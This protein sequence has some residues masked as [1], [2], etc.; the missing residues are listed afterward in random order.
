M[1]RPI[2]L[3]LSLL[4]GIVILAGA[5]PGNPSKVPAGPK[6]TAAAPAKASAP[7]A[8][9]A[10]K[11]YDKPA[12]TS[13]ASNPI[14]LSES[15]LSPAEV[16]AKADKILQDEI[17][18]GS[19]TSPAG[20]CDDETFL[21]RVTLDLVGGI[22]TPEELTKFILDNSPTK[23]AAVV[24][25]LLA[26]EGYGRNWAHYWRD[27]ILARRSE[28]RALIVAQPL[29]KYMEEE[30][31][32][33]TPWDVL[34]RSFITAKGP[35]AEN[36]DTA[37]FMAQ[38]G[39][40]EDVASEITRIFM[41]IQISCA[42]CHNHPTDRW[43]REQF[44]ELAAFFPR[45]A[46]RPTNVDNVRSFEVVG[47]DRTPM[48]GG[49]G[50]MN[51][52]PTGE[53]F[54]TD[55]KNPASKGTR[56]E[57]VFFATGDKLSPGKTDEERRKDLAEWMTSNR[58]E[59]FAKAIIN[60]LWSEL[61]GEGFYEPVDDMGPDRGCTAPK[62]MQLLAQ[63]FVGHNYDVKWLF[64]TIMD[65]AAYQRESRSRRNP[66]ETPFAS[67]THQQLRADQIYLSLTKALGM[68]EPQEAAAGGRPGGFG[69]MGRNPR[70]QFGT[71]FN[72]DPSTRRDEVSGSIPQALLMMNSSE[73]ARYETGKNSFTALGKLL[74]DTKNDDAVVV[75]LYLRCLARVPKDS[76]IKTCLEH[77]KKVSSRTEAF[78]D[79]LWSLVNS[80]EFLHRK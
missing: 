47:V 28:D 12:P 61:V 69:G 37:I 49:G 56:M 30:L 9:A 26:K 44:H 40:T 11:T 23:R 29:T 57:P 71:T 13:K 6:A 76:E 70:G 63:E 1:V 68:G 18:A 73:L 52:R 54:M 62:T 17:L 78:E 36:G 25:Q 48:F 41:G 21:R 65:T 60:R 24:E 33:N 45:V 34:A 32:K 20:K 43:Q 19:K 51:R 3:S 53:H 22:P 2:A 66:A 55:L 10:K 15:K 79:V 16:A 8:D 77:V 58:D 75:E 80:T 31:N 7:A 14:L 64:R 67:S 42:N 46:V 39:N 4:S 59:W 38:M 27:V 35:I 50:G 5:A 74:A 72:Y